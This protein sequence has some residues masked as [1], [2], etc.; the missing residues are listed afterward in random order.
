MLNSPWSSSGTSSLPT[1]GYKNAAD[2]TTAPAMA[3]I[4][5]MMKR[6]DE[7][8]AVEGIDR[9]VEARRFRRGVVG[10][11]VLLL[12]PHGAERRREREGDEH[13]DQDGGGRRQPEAVEVPADLA[14]HERHR[15]E[16]H[17]QRE[18]RGH[19][20]QADLLRGVGGRFF[21]GDAFFLDVPE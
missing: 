13:R 7:H 14:G 6:P 16:N 8:P 20:G 15:H 17:D 1:Y 9:R 5:A 21:R 18:R 19:D 11:R 2:T 12:Q 4:W 10:F 3:I